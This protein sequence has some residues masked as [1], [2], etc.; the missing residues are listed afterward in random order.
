LLGEHT[1]GVLR[2]IGLDGDAAGSL[3]SDGVAITS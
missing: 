1:L 3:V 2:E